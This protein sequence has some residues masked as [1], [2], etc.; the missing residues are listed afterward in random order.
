MSRIGK[1]PINVPSG[2]DLKINGSNVSVK[3]P[4]GQL[5]RVLHPNMKIEL[6][7]GV[8][9]VTRP[10]D[11]R[12]DRSLHGLTR[13]LI[14][15]MVIGV[16]E[17]YSKQLNIVGVGYRVE[18]KGKNLVL[19]LGHSHAI[20]YPAPEGVEF[21]VDPKKNTIVVKGTNKESVGQT[22]AEIRGFRP[23]EPYKGKGVMYSTERIRRK[24]GKAA[25]GK[26]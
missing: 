18:L 17:G 5:Q 22:A 4:K 1:K 21:D 6:K 23:P 19:N 24:A 15:N 25:V 8:V 14:N 16:T 13:T 12:L 20:N 9:T 26:G 10:T 3:G 2:V 11:G 7:D